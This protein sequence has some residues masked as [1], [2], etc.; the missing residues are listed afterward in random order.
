MG[1]FNTEREEFECNNN[2]SHLSLT[3]PSLRSNKLSQ[4]GKVCIETRDL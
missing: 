4:F 2:S 1:G 3:L